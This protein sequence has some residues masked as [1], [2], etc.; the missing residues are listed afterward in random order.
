MINPRSGRFPIH[1]REESWTCSRREERPTSGAVRLDEPETPQRP[2]PDKTKPPQS[3]TAARR[4][5]APAARSEC[6]DSPSDSDAAVVPCSLLALS[7]PRSC[8]LGPL[9]DPP[10]V[11]ID[12]ELSRPQRLQRRLMVPEQLLV[13][14]GHRAPRWIRQGRSRGRRSHWCS[15][16]RGR[17]AGGSARTGRRPPSPSPV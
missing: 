7:R 6:L 4:S 14:D 11:A 2:G 10:R 3:F 15:R 5:A 9:R 12:P 17:C 16:R 1:R 8:P 13:E